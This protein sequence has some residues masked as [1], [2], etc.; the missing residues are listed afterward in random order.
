MKGSVPVSLVHE[1]GNE[2][3]FDRILPRK[4]IKIVFKKKSNVVNPG[5]RPR[6]RACRGF[7][8]L[9]FVHSPYA[10]AVGQVY[11]SPAAFHAPLRWSTRAG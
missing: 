4:K 7:P 6:N 10:M 3:R 1:I 8:A 9:S 5:A 11:R 2:M